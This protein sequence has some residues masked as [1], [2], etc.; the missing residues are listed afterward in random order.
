M[1]IRFHSEATA[2]LEEALA[3][4]AVRSPDA[5]RKFAF[6]IDATLTQ[7]AAAPERFAEVLPEVRGITVEKF[8]YQIVYR[9]VGETAVVLAVSHAKRRP[10]YWKRREP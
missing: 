10:G 8:P 5:E 9:L 6:A 1:R 4:Y 3:W 7:L 2:E